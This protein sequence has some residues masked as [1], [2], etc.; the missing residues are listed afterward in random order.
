MRVTHGTPRNRTPGPPLEPASLRRRAAAS[1]INAA[2]GLSGLGTA[3]GV[4]VGLVGS[5]EKLGY[6]G[7]IYRR[8]VANPQRIT[9]PLQSRPVK[10]ALWVLTLVTPLRRVKRRNPGYAMLGLRLLDARGGG[11]PTRRQ[12]FVRSTAKRLWPVLWR[13]VLP[14]PKISPRDH[15]QLRSELEAARAWFPDD[16][17]ARDHAL[18]QV[19]KDR[20]VNPMQSCAPVLARIPLLA[21]IDLPLFPAPLRQSL[22]DRLAG[23]AIM[24]ERPSSAQR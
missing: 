17:E 11:R 7:E 16:P 6:D 21:A 5:L 15:D 1:L 12:M 19:Y 10:L 2:V 3:I 20:Q 4:G 14:M 22:P 13:Q 24:R 8:M 9:A 23:T 18:M